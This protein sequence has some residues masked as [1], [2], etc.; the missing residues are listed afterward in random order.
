MTLNEAARRLGVTFWQ[1]RSAV[2][3]GRIRATVEPV[4]GWWT[5]AEEEVER[6]RA[7]RSW[8]RHP[9]RPQGSKNRRAA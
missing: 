3:A 4:S 7:D 2:Y 9:G 6:C 8:Q 5:I 1:V